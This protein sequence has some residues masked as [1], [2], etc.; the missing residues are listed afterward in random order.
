MALESIT[1]ETEYF[2]AETARANGTIKPNGITPYS[3]G[4]EWGE[5]EALGETEEAGSGSAN[6]VTS[7]QAFL[8]G[9][10]PN[11]T[12]YVRAWAKHAAETIHGAIKSFKTNEAPEPTAETLDPTPTSSG[13][14]VTLHGTGTVG[15]F[16]PLE[17]Y[18]E[19]GTTTEYGEKFAYEGTPEE[20]R[21]AIIATTPGT[22][23]HYR[24]VTK[25]PE[26]TAFGEDKAFTAPEP[27]PEEEV[28][29]V[30]EFEPGDTIR[31][32]A[33]TDLDGAMTIAA[34]V[35]VGP[36]TDYGSPLAIIP[37]DALPTN[38]F[39]WEKGTLLTTL[40]AIEAEQVSPALRV[41]G[42]HGNNG[43]WPEERWLLIVATKAAGENASRLHVY[44]F[45]EEEWT[46][47]DGFETLKDPVDM[48]GGV[49]LMGSTEEGNGEEVTFVNKY[50]GLI[51]AVAAWASVLDDTQV[52]NLLKAGSVEH[53]SSPLHLWI[54]D[55]ESAS[56][57]IMDEAGSVDERAESYEAPTTV[58]K[59]AAPPFPLRGEGE[60]E[61]PGGENT[62]GVDVGGS[63]VAAETSILV[64]GSLVPFKLS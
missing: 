53:W 56:E 14:H 25:N 19:F 61:E 29:F 6:T 39:E 63:L 60:P 22:T 17:A 55:Q 37:S 23:Y 62:V 20:A 31:F 34:Y 48:T 15:E 7:Y 50:D 30:R 33:L 13:R 35:N 1:A 21:S 59:K 44:D 58:A 52:E 41:N 24:Y 32:D 64:S 43:A 45:V 28:T 27:E 8:S 18:F 54:L 42:N 11:T 5:S 46:H 3:Y 9:L 49:T 12:Y 26:G 51:A 38:P 36:E 57:Q 2:G 47:E 10:K 4:F 16:F 40:G